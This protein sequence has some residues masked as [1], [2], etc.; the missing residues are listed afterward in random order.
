MSVHLKHFEYPAFHAGDAMAIWRNSRFND[1][2]AGIP[3]E[4]RDLIAGRHVDYPD[5]LKILRP[6]SIDVG[7]IQDRAQA[8]MTVFVDPKPCSGRCGEKTGSPGVCHLIAANLL[9]VGV[10]DEGLR[11][12]R[13]QTGQRSRAR[14]TEF[15]KAPLT[16]G[17]RHVFHAKSLNHCPVILVDKHCSVTRNCYSVYHLRVPEYCNLLQRFRVDYCLCSQCVAANSHALT[18]RIARMTCRTNC[19]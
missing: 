3:L 19:S 7:E 12:I 5:A 1:M 15:A 18:L 2:M 11:G 8:R 14:E 9:S 6:P 10:D 17:E 13:I 4:P 16:A